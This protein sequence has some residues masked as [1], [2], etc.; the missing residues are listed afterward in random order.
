MEDENLVERS[1]ELGGVIK[2]E[3]KDIYD[4][5]NVGDVRN[6]GL[7]LG[8]EIVEDKLSKTPAEP[9]KI[10]KIISVCKSQGLIIGKNGDTVAGHDNILTI[11]LPLSMTDEDCYFLTNTL[12]EA[13]KQI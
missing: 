5:P 10:G 1:A 2:S 4:H 11:A 12:K 13:I 8:I 9:E 6:K 3:M 7:L